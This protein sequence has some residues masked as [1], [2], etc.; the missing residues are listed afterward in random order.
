VQYDASDFGFLRLAVSKTQ[1]VGTYMSAPYSSGTTP[2]AKVIDTFT[3]DLVKN[4]V[5]TGTSS[6]GGGGGN[7]PKPTPKKKPVP[8]K[9]KR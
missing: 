2:A 9:K 1:I 7:N 4:T 8:K 6:G 3:V 5:V